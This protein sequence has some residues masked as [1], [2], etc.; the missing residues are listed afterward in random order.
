MCMSMR[1]RVSKSTCGGQS[2]GA[3]PPLQP[4]WVWRVGLRSRSLAGVT[5]RSQCDG[6]TYRSP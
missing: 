2:S 6:L 3:G 4:V 1:K 5:Y